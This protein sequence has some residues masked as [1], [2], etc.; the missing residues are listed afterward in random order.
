M[1]QTGWQRDKLTGLISSTISGNLIWNNMD[2]SRCVT[3]LMELICDQRQTKHHHFTGNTNT[4]TCILKLH[5]N[6]SVTRGK[7]NTIT[8]Q[9]TLS[10]ALA[11]LNSMELICNQTETKAITLQA[12]LSHTPALL[13]CSMSCGCFAQL[14]TKKVN[15]C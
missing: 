1:P 15:P 3:R 7:Q 13:L 4:C 14:L 2:S 6:S 10:H 5:V 9:A 12:A 8:L 11:F